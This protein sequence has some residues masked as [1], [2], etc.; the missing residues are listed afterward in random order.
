MNRYLSRIVTI[1]KWIATIVAVLVLTIYF[2][3]AFDARQMSP[4]GPEYR[5][6]FAHEFTAAEEEQTDWAAYLDIE[7][8]LAI[9]LE[10]KIA[11]DTRSDSPADRYF[12]GSLTYPGNYPGNW[13]R[14]WEMSVPSPR[15]VAVLLHGLTDSPYSMRATAQTLADAGYNIVVPR[16]PGHGF[17][18]GGLL[19]ARWEDWTAAVRI[20]IRR[21]MG[22]DGDDQALLLVGYSNGGLLAVD[23][24][25]RCDEFA[26]LPCPD[27]L[28][29][30][31]PGIAITPAAVTM[32][33]HAAVSWI[34]YFEQFK[35]LS[36]LPEIDP[37]KFTSFP[38]RA[39]WEV[40]KLSKRMHKRLA[41]P[42]EAA[43]LPPILTFQSIVDYTVGATAIVRTLYDRL[44][45]NGSELVIYD[46][47]RNSTLLYLMKNRPADPAEH[48][49]SLAPLD[50][51]VTILRNR[52]RSGNAIESLTLAAGQTQPLISA[53]EHNWPTEI[54]SLSHIAIPF[55]DDD[56]LYG[57][58]STQ[59]ENNPG[60]V[61]GAL[62]PRGEKG[63]LLLTP[64]YF[65]RTRHNPFYAFQARHLTEW[66]DQL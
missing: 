23:Y 2:G 42:A 39:A 22:R 61:F 6:E 52:D 50:F 27:G 17:A 65:L 8:E 59:D 57:N 43:K 34:P 3:R 30:M 20:A 45:P 36:I 55:R 4:L 18:V 44:P 13:N 40:H 51:G 35:W 7:K 64:D 66:L 14:S 32:N 19:Q 5:I 38:K 63:V 15:G 53:T 37:F 54:Y 16:M 46:I 41:K 29:L 10:R 21:A 33:W 49:S 60:V 48:F 9:E 24:A 25:L 47:N 31:S 1:G 62:A 56:L 12:A 11:S 26:D 28:V 58:G